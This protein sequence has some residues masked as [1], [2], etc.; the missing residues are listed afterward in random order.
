M[1]FLKG[2]SQYVKNI[3]ILVGGSSLAQLLI[4]LSSPILSRIYNGEDYG[5]YG[6]YISI[7]IILVGVM[8]FR[9]DQAIVLEKDDAD[10]MLLAKAS[11]FFSVI[12][13]ILCFVVLWF[14]SDEIIDLFGLN[15][16][17][18]TAILIPVYP[19][20]VSVIGVMAFLFTKT[21]LFKSM[22]I[23]QIAKSA[24]VV[25]GQISFS[26]IFSDY[27]GLL[28][29]QFLGLTMALIMSFFLWGDNKSFV[30]AISIMRSK[31]LLKKHIDF[32]TYTLPQNLINSFSQNIP[33]ILLTTLFGLEVA[34]FYWFTVRILQMPVFVVGLSIR[35]VFLKRASELHNEGKSFLDL[36]LKSTLGLV[37]V[38]L[39][40]AIIL[41][42]FGEDLFEFVFG[43]E[44]EV[45]G[46]YSGYLAIYLGLSLSNA[47]SI[48][49]FQI[50]QKQSY[51]LIV[52][53][54]MMI[55][56]VLSI[57]VGFYFDSSLL[58][59]KLFSA[60]GFLFNFAIILWMVLILKK[61]DQ[62]TASTT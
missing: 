52:E 17:R 28:L 46:T 8:T 38:G 39:V 31:E 55:F 13:F 12:V 1:Q 48:V 34:G 32:P 14:F 10:S 43:R 49:S 36:F 15:I 62:I 45:A 21:G 23:V 57:Y 40:P 61:N 33:T 42:F 4:V 25:A 56:R 9:Y 22:S 2:K 47:P 11:I 50:L 54:L 60:V 24:F 18:K 35:K 20:L 7:G 53:V 58:S 51:L 30:S 44:W 26:I 16:D 27:L 3:S 19:L 59:I 29:G 6:T 37:I 41:F 5:L